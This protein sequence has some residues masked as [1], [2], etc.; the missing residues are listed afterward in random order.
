MVLPAQKGGGGVIPTLR[1]IETALKSVRLNPVRLEADVV[2]AICEALVS[3]RFGFIREAV[4][5]SGCR[6]DL[7]VSGGI[8]IEVKK[9]K[10]NTR[11]VAAQIRRYAASP[12][13]QS[14]ILV[15]ERGLHAHLK[16]ANGKPVRYVSLASNWGLVT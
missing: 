12:K 13:V 15:S 14:I 16:E 8:A 4:I 2:G 3:R 6:V 10:P 9:G 5:A 1:D 7:L 11:K